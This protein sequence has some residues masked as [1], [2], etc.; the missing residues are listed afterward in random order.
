MNSMIPKISVVIAAYNEEKLIAKCIEA[1]QKQTYPK[2]RF[3][4]IIVDN[5]S[6][7]KTAEICKKMGVKVYTYTEVQGCGPSR[8]YGKS[9][10]DGSIIVFT[11]ADSF[12]PPDWLERIYKALENP[13]VYML[14]GRPIPDEKSFLT[15]FIFLYYH[16]FYLVNYVF[17]KPLVWG[18]TMAIKRSAYEAVNGIDTQMLSSDDWDLAI[19]IQKRFGKGSVK[20]LSDMRVV[21][22]TRKQSKPGVL[23]QYAIDG[24]NNYVNLVI[25][26]RK[27]AVPVFHTR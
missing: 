7:D 2:E 17:G 20:Y 14:S 1:I 9:K 24:V 16:W 15:Q 13:K 5:G 10:A 18:S 12:V 22:S 25:L 21:T 23:Y 8:E 4:L 19:R 6:K 26:G 27:K 3:E 11:D